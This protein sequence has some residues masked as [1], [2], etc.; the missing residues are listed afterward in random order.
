MVNVSIG[1]D[2][3]CLREVRLHLTGMSDGLATLPPALPGL[4]LALG[5]LTC[6]G[7]VF[8]GLSP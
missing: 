5:Y 3:N 7:V 8:Q 4:V 1:Q 2:T 6:Y